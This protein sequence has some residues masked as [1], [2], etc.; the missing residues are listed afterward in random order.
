ME[1]SILSHDGDPA[2]DVLHV[3]LFEHALVVFGL[4]ETEVGLFFCENGGLARFGGDEC[5]LTELH[6]WLE[7]YYFFI[8]ISVRE[9]VNF[10]ERLQIF[11]ELGVV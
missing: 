8:Y 5:V 3:G 1:E 10:F 11:E 2:L 6:P 7:L 9:I 4:Q